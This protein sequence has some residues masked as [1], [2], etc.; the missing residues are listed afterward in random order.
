MRTRGTA[1]WRV[2]EDEPEDLHLVLFVRDCLRLPVPAEGL[3]GPLTPPAP[4]LSG[5]LEASVRGDAAAAWPAW[6]RAALVAHRATGRPVPPS[7]SIA[8]HHQAA[9][10]RHAADD[11]PRFESLSAVPALR[12]AARTAFA[13]FLQWWSPPWPA[14]GAPPRPGG[15]LALPGVHG[16]LIDLHLHRRTV[17]EVVIRLE[18]ELAR[19]ANPFD[20]RIDILAVTEPAVVVQDEHHALVSAGLVRNETDYRDWL[21]ATLR[22]LA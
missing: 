16:E 11:G 2:A 7:A 20:L 4:D 1:S 15:P 12:A 14:A 21:Y 8:E 19:T 5:L 9:R 10:L 6:W 22:P 17:N 3:P 13:P 18:R